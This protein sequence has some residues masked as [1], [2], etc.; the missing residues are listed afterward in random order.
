MAEMM[1]GEQG[2]ERHVQT[3]LDDENEFIKHNPK[4]SATGKKSVDDKLLQ[5]W[6]DDKAD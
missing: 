6:E 3:L 4:P 5:Q 1:Y 2:T